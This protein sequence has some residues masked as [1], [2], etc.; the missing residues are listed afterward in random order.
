MRSSHLILCLILVNI[1]EVG[2][3]CGDPTDGFTVVPL[4]EWNFEIQKPYDKPLEERYSFTDGIRRLWVYADDKPH[5]PNS[6]TMPRT[7]IRISGLDYSSGVWQ[8]EGY[9]FV[10]NGT[11][12]AIIVQIHG[13][14]GHATTLILRMYEGDVRYYLRDL[15][16]TNLYDK[17][18]RVNVI[19][20]RDQGIVEVYLDGTLKFTTQDRGPGDLY[21]KCGVYAAPRT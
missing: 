19:H 6:T 2:H 7:E 15:I 18:F 9:G 1:N 17:W 21:F 12:G 5:E 11:S 13:G 10:P 14:M 4:T 16:A 8:F 20:D 3:V